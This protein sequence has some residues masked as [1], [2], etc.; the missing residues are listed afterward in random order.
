MEMKKMKKALVLTVAVLLSAC[1][2]WPPRALMAALSSPLPPAPQTSDAYAERLRVFAKFVRAEMAKDK[3][4]GLTIG[5]MKDD[6]VWTEGFGYADLEN[7]TPAKADS[8]YRL[9]SITKS[10][11]GAAIAQLAE[12]GKI[13]LDAEIQTYVPYYPKQKWPV[14]V[15]QL[16]VHLG[17]GQVGSGLSAEYLSPREVV[18]RISKYPITKEP[19]VE[20]DYQTSG[21]NLLGAAIEEVSGQSFGNYLRENLFLPLGM[22]D[23]R[24][25]SVSELI[26]NRVRGYGLVNGEVRN[27]QFIDVSSRFGG[28]GLTG[29]VP[30]LLRWPKGI[31]S[32]KVLSKKFVDEMLSP[33]T[34]KAGRYNGL[35]DGDWYYTLGWLVF[36]LNGNYVVQQSGSQKGTDTTL[37]HFP[38]KNLTI[39]YAANLEFSPQEKYVR[40]LYELLT[41]EPWAINVYA[42][43]Q[44]GQPIYKAMSSVFN[45]GSLYFEQHGQ[46]V[47]TDPQQLASAFAYF[48]KATNR[49]ALQADYRKFVQQVSDGRHPIAGIP[50]IKMGSYIAQ[51]LKEKYGAQRFDTYHTMGAIPFFADYVELYK[52]NPKHPKE[53]RFD[54]SFEKM[55]ARWNQ[56]WARTWNDY[57]RQTRLTPDTDFAA[58][59]ARL[60]KEFAGAE[61]YPDFTTDI[62]PIQTGVVALHAGK[63]GVD[64]YP[65]SDELN[66][67]WGFFLLA[68]ND[69]EEGRALYKSAIGPPEPALVYFKRAAE[70][71]P[72]GVARAK[73]FL[74]ITHNWVG[75]P[76]VLNR[77]I[78]L[79]QIGVAL[80]PTETALFERLGDFLV[81]KGQKEQAIEAYRRALVIAPKLPPEGQDAET[82]IARKTLLPTP[83]GNTTFKLAGY[84]KAKAVALAGTFNNWSPTQTFFTKAGDVWVCSVELPPGKHVYRFVVDGEWIADPNNPQTERDEK[85][86]VNSVLLVAAR[87]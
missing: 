54:A 75:R 36:P 86:N 64:L 60:R 24:M 9:A 76:E 30:D 38:S 11:T 32:G 69:T 65:R 62:Q 77:G 48:N 10:M 13:D 61:V 79:L 27:A 63:L 6:Y 25:D 7:K 19:G 35:G 47:S 49:E 53:L 21:Y 58:V 28:G 26:P 34:T 23:T 12:R 41:N 39:A 78:A 59:G 5:F 81:R 3:I 42:R 2:C 74:D 70:I 71:N 66:F 29:T 80:H 46:P 17:G 16:L 51:Q 8:A 40:R 15:R 52:S 84:P 72:E 22:K 45:Y 57:T 55:L 37:Y 83:N 44:L 43:D 67:N 20:F 73:T 85:G 1:L 4:P 33:V 50:F 82:F 31:L 14:T 87:P 56:D 18:A 68:V